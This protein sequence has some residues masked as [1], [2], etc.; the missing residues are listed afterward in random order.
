MAAAESQT[1]F[2]DALA[3]EKGIAWNRVYCFS[4]DDFC[5][6]GMPEQYTCGHQVQRQLWSRVNPAQIYRIRADAPS[7]EDEAA[8]FERVLR[9]AG[10]MDIVCQGI[11]T[12][13]HLALNEPF[14][15]N[16][17]DPAW[18][19]V[20]EIAEQSKRQLKQDPNFMDLGYV[21]DE[22][23]TMTIPAILSSRY[24]FTMVPLALKRPIMTKLLALK[25]PTTDLPASIL[26][27][28]DGTIFLDRNS[29][30]V[31]L[32]RESANARPPT[33]PEDGNTGPC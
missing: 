24:V 30:P 22:G 9:D 13:G 4:I 21:P 7:P 16:F 18:V 27:R 1:T 32:Q 2:L 29:C 15:T 19:R 6:V 28:V 33:G 10:R 3:V 14:E 11:G 31:A 5:H 23:I 8:R 20:V 12:S 26:L 25:A 17:D